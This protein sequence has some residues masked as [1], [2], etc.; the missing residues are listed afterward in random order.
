MRTAGVVAAVVLAM[1][2]PAPT[3]ADVP[4]DGDADVTGGGQ[5]IDLGAKEDDAAPPVPPRVPRGGDGNGSNAVAKL[6]AVPTCTAIDLVGCAFQG[7]TGGGGDAAPPPPPNP[8]ELAEEATGNLGLPVPLA[9]TS[10][11]APVETLVG[12]QTWLWVAPE[13]WRPITAS[14]TAGSTTVSATV[15]PTGARWNMGEGSTSC[16]GPGRPWRKGLGQAVRTSCGYTYETTSAS[17]PGDRFRISVSV[18]YSASWTCTG[19]CTSAGGDLGS[20]QSPAST[21]QL[22]VAERE[23]VVVR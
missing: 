15:R 20:L 21:A 16:A 11:R 13:Q 6:P 19:A 23:P 22:E 12:L 17:Q 7:V 10:P 14:V 2:I 18:T 5:S 1:G 8:I 4:A 9:H 3:A